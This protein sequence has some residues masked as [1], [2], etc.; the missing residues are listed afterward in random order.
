MSRPGVH[1]EPVSASYRGTTTCPKSDGM[2]PWATRSR[3]Y[4]MCENLLGSRFRRWTSAA[5]GPFKRCVGFLASLTRRRVLN[6]NRSALEA[7]RRR[8]RPGNAAMSLRI[9]TRLQPHPESASPCSAP[10]GWPRF[11][12]ERRAD[13]WRVISPPLPLPVAPRKSPWPSQPHLLRA[14]SCPTQAP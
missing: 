13:C 1:R 4:P 2:T 10:R 6:G 11:R 7:C 3:D 5:N 14:G 8:H 9:A 12:P